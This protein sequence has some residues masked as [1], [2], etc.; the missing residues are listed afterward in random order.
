MNLYGTDKY[1]KILQ[2]KPQG[3]GKGPR[4]QQSRQS[5]YSLQL[6]EKQ[7]AR[8]MYGLSERQFRR[9]YT[10][11]AKVSGQTG[12]T[13]KQLLERRL[14]NVLYRAG[15]AM[16]RMQA[17][18]FVS[19]GLFQVD[20]VRVTIPSFEVKPGQV[21]QLRERLKSS[22][23]VPSVLNAHQNY[24]PPSW[25]KV[26]PT[27]MKIEIVS[28]PQASDAEQAVDTRQIIEFYSR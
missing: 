1:D 4:A 8:D 13:L 27:G 21:I 25:L 10:T 3:P 14:D 5:E 26:D 15:L 12:D 2:R 11:A 18:Q 16:T 9:L 17:R 24:T 20:G 22:P 7:K 6:Q 19:H 23:L 28:L